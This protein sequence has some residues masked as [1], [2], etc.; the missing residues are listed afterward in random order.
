MDKIKKVHEFV[1][2]KCNL[3]SFK[4]HILDVVESAKFLLKSYPDADETVVLL[5]AYLH[6]I[7]RDV[8]KQEDHENHGI[9]VVKNLLSE[10]DYDE[11]TIKKVCEC[12]AGHNLS[13]NININAEIV[14]NADAITNIRRC[15]LVVAHGFQINDF[16][17]GNTF[18]WVN[19]KM[20]RNWNDKISLPEARKKVEEHYKAFKFLIKELI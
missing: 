10:L 8:V 11:E 15:L 18:D 19:K 2:E 14:R 9:E 6:D 12:V 5:G 17:F 7:G 13:N 3:T 1:E 4:Y 20:N 16:D